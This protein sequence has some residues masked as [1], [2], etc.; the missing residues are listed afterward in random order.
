MHPKEALSKAAKAKLTI[1]NYLGGQYFLTADEVLLE[2]DKIFLIERK[3]S[4]MKILPSK[5][6]IKDGLLKMILYC[7]LKNLETNG[8]RVIPRA[9]LLLTS[10]NLKSEAY[11]YEDESKRQT[12]LSKNGFSFRQKE[13]IELLFKEANANNFTV[14]LK[15]ERL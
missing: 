12:F 14:A 9:M 8:M 10:E 1:L 13:F 7:N 11:S 4:R 5:R 15:Q 6:D 3:H 2:K